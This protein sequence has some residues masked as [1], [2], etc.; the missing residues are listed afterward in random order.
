[1]PETPFIHCTTVWREKKKKFGFDLT[2]RVS[3]ARK[4]DK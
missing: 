3:T 2:T 1:M 4:I